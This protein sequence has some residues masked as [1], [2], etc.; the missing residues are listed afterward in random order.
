MKH[1]ASS[2]ATSFLFYDRLFSLRLDSKTEWAREM[3]E[4]KAQ[5]ENDLFVFCYL[6][7]FTVRPGGR[8]RDKEWVIVCWP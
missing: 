5:R 1:L 7:F 6:K 3:M 8:A 2:P 4:R